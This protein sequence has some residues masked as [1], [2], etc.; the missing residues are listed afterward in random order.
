[1]ERLIK[2]LFIF[3]GL[4]VVLGGAVHLA[5]KPTYKKYTEDQIE[6]M[7]PT[8]VLGEYYLEGVG[9]PAQTYKMDEVTYRVLG[10]LF[11]IVCRKFE[12]DGDIY[13][14]VVI[15]SR[16]KDSFHDPNICF[17]GQGWQIEKREEITVKTDTRG[18]IPLTLIQAYNT[19]R[20]YRQI[21]AFTYKGPDGFVANTNVLKF[22]F[23]MEEMRLG[24]R[25]D[26]VFFRFIPEFAGRGDK[27][28]PMDVRRERL[29]RFIKA[30]LDESG[31]TSMNEETGV[32]YL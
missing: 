2:N 8:E 26:G 3:T 17:A 9:D 27:E 23:L 20:K 22:Q 14:A 5:P 16:T 15:A 29:E 24:N 18:D 12:I 28:L 25:L 6:Q 13:D 19:E 21:A 10:P 30:Y 7:A 1:M 32:P 31:K 11:G 4:L